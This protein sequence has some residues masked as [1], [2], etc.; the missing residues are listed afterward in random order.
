[1]PLGFEPVVPVGADGLALRQ[2]E[3]V[4]VDGGLLGGGT[5]AFSPGAEGR[6]NATRLDLIADKGFRQRVPNLT[7]LDPVAFESLP[8]NRNRPGR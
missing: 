5:A 2:P 7:I 8:W 6:R 3:V 4:G 1:M